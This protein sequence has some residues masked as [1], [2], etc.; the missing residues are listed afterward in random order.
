[1]KPNMSDNPEHIIM[2]QKLNL[3]PRRVS[4]IQPLTIGPMTE[5]YRVQNHVGILMI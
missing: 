1:M 2:I 3:H 4:T 5:E